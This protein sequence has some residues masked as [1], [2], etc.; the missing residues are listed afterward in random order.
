[1]FNIRVIY[2]TIRILLSEKSQC[3]FVMNFKAE[4]SADLETN[5]LDWQTIVNDEPSLRKCI[6]AYLFDLPKWL[7][8]QPD[9]NDNYK[10]NVIGDIRLCTCF[11]DSDNHRHISSIF[12]ENTVGAALVK[13]EAEAASDLTKVGRNLYMTN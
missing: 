2:P 1:M 12:F 10:D 7:M 8:N 11:E 6:Q 3:P 4:M 5:Q 13:S 9:F